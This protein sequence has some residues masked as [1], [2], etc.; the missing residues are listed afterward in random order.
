MTTVSGFSL[1]KIWK[2]FSHTFKEQ[3]MFSQVTSLD[4]VLSAY[5]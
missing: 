3:Y 4:F 2:P 5:A 1:N